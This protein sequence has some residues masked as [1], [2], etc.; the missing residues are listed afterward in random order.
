[1]GPVGGLHRDEGGPNRP[2]KPIKEALIDLRKLLKAIEE[3]QTEDILQRFLKMGLRPNP[4]ALRSA[5]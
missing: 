5:R 4:H 1:M 2:A 3:H